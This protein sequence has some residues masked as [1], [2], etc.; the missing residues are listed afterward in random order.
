[1]SLFEIGMLVCFGLSWPTSIYKSFRTKKVS[2]KSP[3]F[4]GIICIGYVF[5]ILNKMKYPMIIDG[6]EKID[7]VIWFYVCILV[8][9]LFDLFLYFLYAKND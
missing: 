2:G 8:L 3:L 9:V 1:M 6:V 4:L 7:P 5:G